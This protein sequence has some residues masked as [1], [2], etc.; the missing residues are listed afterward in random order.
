MEFCEHGD[1]PLGIIKNKEFIEQLIDY[2]L[3]NSALTFI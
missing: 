3:L 2:Q 1:E